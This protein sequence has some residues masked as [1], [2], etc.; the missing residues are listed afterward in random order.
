R[1]AYSK[2]FFERW[3][4]PQFTTLIVAGDVT[5][6]AV[7]PL[8]K[9][10][11]GNWKGPGA[12]GPGA[13]GGNAMPVQIPKEPPPNGAKYVHVPWTS[14]TLPWVTVAFPGPAF[15]ENGKEWGGVEGVG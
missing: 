1:S 5:P 2:L 4:R 15:D 10:Y 11:W 8:V 6:D 13:E 3:Y 12:R 9:K 7:L 14:D